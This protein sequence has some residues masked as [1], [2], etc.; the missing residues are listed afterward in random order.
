[1]CVIDIFT[2]QVGKVLFNLYWNIVLQCCVGFC[3]CIYNSVQLLSWR[4]SGPPI[5]PLISSRNNL[6]KLNNFISSS[7]RSQLSLLCTWHVFSTGLWAQPSS[8]SI[9][10][11][12]EG[13][14]DRK[15]SM[16]TQEDEQINGLLWMIPLWLWDW[17]SISVA[18]ATT[19]LQVPWNSLGL[20]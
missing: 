12:P 19:L 10:Y 5:P 6:L 1:M 4:W 16:N 14:A 11:S 8:D 7:P 9:L 3:C 2:C 13:L 18:R 17:H 20:Q 15:G